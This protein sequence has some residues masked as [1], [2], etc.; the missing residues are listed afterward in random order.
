MIAF[1]FELADPL[2]LHARPVARIAEASGSH[3]SSVRLGVEGSAARV[4]GTDLLGLM[5]LDAR[6]G[7]VLSVSVC[8]P[9]EDAAAA[10]LRAALEG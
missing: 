3:M 7:D 4:D 9:D 6:C 10:A 5:A 1:T 2:G 8:G